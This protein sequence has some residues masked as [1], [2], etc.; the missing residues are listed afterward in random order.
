VTPLLGIEKCFGE[1]GRADVRREGCPLDDGRQLDADPSWL[2]SVNPSLPPMRPGQPQGLWGVTLSGAAFPYYQYK[3]GPAAGVECSSPHGYGTPIRLGSASRV[4]DPLPATGGHYF[5]CVLGS[6]T[7]SSELGGQNPRFA[8]VVSVE[9]DLIPPR[10][11]PELRVTELSESY[12]VEWIYAPPEISLYEVK[13]GR[14]AETDCKDPSG[15]RTPLLGFVNLPK[16]GAPY[17]V[18][19]IGFDLAGNATPPTERVLG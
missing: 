2:A 3:T 6:A 13:Y 8:T 17:R 19:A 7:A 18:C 9:I 14:F 15:Y 1:D 12:R 11:P 5:L 4:D 10:V 16:S